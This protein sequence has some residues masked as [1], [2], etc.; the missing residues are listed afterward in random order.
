[1]VEEAVAGAR[2][3]YELKDRCIYCAIIRQE[4]A[5]GVRMVT[6]TGRFAVLEPYAPRFPFE[7]W[8]LPKGHQ[9]HFEESDAATL[10]NLAGVLRST[11]RKIDKVLERPA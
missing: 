3:F 7:T 1:M 6:E 11:M 10:E 2:F 8:I 5:S 9:S 4:T